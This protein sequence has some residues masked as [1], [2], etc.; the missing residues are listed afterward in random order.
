MAFGVKLTRRVLMDLA[1]TIRNQTHIP[2]DTRLLFGRALADFFK[3][4]DPF[5]DRATFLTILT[6]DLAYDRRTEAY[7]KVETKYDQI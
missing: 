4:E 2:R 7:T 3:N 6:G 1:K 5:F